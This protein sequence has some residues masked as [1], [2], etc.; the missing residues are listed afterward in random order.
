MKA[1]HLQA[2]VANSEKT[3]FFS[4]KIISLFTDRS[5]VLWIGT[6]NEGLFRLNRGNRGREKFSYLKHQANNPNSL[7]SS[8]VTA[9]AVDSS[10][11]CWIGSQRGLTKYNPKTSQYKHFFTAKNKTGPGT[12]HIA[13]LH[14]DGSGALWITV[15]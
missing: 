4:N 9:I 8:D 6:A 13:D 11:C 14:A 15:Q 1:E 12:N 10:G 5:G 2:G 3:K 7:I